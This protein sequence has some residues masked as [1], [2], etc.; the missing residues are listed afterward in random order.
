VRRTLVARLT[1]QPG[2]LYKT[3]MCI[4]NEDEP[5]HYIQKVCAISS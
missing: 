4:V 1:S 5:R 2:V 3:S